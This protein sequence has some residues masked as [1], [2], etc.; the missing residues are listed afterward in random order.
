MKEAAVLV[1][2]P[3]LPRA[4]EHGE[5]PHHVGLDE[6]GGSLDAVVHVALS[7]EM[8]DPADLVA[9]QQ[10]RDQL[11]ILDIALHQLHLGKPLDLLGIRSVGELVEHHDAICWVLPRPAVDEIGA[12]E[13][14]SAGDENGF[15]HGT[16]LHS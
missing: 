7:R 10:V 2:S 14:G 5:G 3:D 16:D 15:G 9:L 8:N 4:F 11:E 1:A 12:D 6:G 13:T